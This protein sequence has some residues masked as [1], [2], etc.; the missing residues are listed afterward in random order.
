MCKSNVFIRHWKT[1]NNA[2]ISADYKS[3]DWT[4]IMQIDKG[5]PNLSLPNYIEEDENMISN[6][7]FLRKTR[8]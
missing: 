6:H 7:A 3:T 8:K 2:A 5:N 1:F 4:N